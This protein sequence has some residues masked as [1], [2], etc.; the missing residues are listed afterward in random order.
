MEIQNKII[1]N[2]FKYKNTIIVGD[3]SSF[4]ARNKI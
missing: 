1:N 4:N 3:N 2:Q